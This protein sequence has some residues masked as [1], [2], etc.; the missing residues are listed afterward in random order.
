MTAPAPPRAI[1]PYRLVLPASADRADWL[2]ARRKGIGSSDIPQVLGVSE[3]GSPQHVY[4][5]KRGELP[6]RDDIG[7]P[8]LWGQLLEE[9]VAREW[10]RRNRA[11]IRRV[12]LIARKDPGMGHHMC[13]LDRLAMECPLNRGERERCAVEVKMRNAWVAGK[14]KRGVPDDVLAQGLWQIHVTGF[15]HIHV[16]VLIGGNDFRQFV[17]RRDEHREL[18]GNLV[19]VADKLWRDIALGHCPPL[20]GV[21]PVEAML[22]LYDT[23][24]PDRA[25]E[26]NL[27]EYPALSVQAINA[28][29]EY[30]T[31]RLEAKAA[32]G[33]QGHAKVALIE[34][35]GSN[36]VAILNGEPAYE[37]RDVTRRT[38]DL[39]RLAERYPEAYAACVE[40]KSGR[41]LSIARQHRLKELAR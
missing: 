40:D 29:L 4:Y 2:A 38:P 16:A 22:D 5:D 8:A 24:H 19:T 21:E 12:G 25:G 20:A 28:L 26:A 9:T 36:T 17:V 1:L 41:Q 6:E 11:V 23:L 32:K 39:E 14:W 37:L 3:W 27:D 31:A 34:M 18:I 10:A 7:E 33:A 35:L 13:T 30:E 15:D